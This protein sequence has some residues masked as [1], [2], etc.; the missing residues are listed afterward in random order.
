PMR[1]LGNDSWVGEFTPTSV[2]RHVFRLESWIEE[3]GL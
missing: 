2:S 3:T 1:D